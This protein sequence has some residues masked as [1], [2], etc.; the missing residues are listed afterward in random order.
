MDTSQSPSSI[1]DPDRVCKLEEGD[2]PSKDE[3]YIQK[4]RFMN[5]EILVGRNAYSNENLVKNHA[6]R[7]C[8]WFHAFHDKGPNVI[9]CCDGKELP[10][11]IVLRRAAGLAV[12]KGAHASVSV[13]P[14][15]DVYKPAQNV[16]GIW[17]TWRRETIEI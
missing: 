12:R 5:Y 3:N 10:P 8:F 4:F 16:I 11:E 9:L 1:S 13:A 15:S 7:N 17:K 14:L 6:H 2:L